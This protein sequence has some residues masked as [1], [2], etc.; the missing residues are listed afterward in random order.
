MERRTAPTMRD[1][2]KWPPTSTSAFVELTCPAAVGNG[3][4]ISDPLG[5][6][7]GGRCCRAHGRA[8][9]NTSRTMLS[10]GARVRL[11]ASDV[12]AM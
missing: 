4:L 6:W 1:A 3:L 2:R 9:R 8:I 10:S 5:L 7:R 11:V 12:K